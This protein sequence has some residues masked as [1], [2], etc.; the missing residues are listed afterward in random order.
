TP[1]R[2]GT[3]IEELHQ[4]NAERAR[5]WPL[6]MTTT[7]THDT[8]RGEDAAARIAVLSEMPEAWRRAVGRW[9]ELARHAR[10]EVDG[11][12]A[13]SPTLEYLFYQSLVGAWPVGWDGREGR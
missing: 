7:S 1:S 3:S 8:K 6:S 2:F 11:Q 10:H 9:S 12:P 5:C 13:P 4:L